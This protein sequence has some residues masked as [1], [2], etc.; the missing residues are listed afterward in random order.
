MNDTQIESLLRQ[1]PRPPAPTGLK[2]QLLADIRL[3]Q[4]QVS[5]V[6]AVDAAPFW[7]RWHPA[8][9]E[10]LPELRATSTAS[11]M[12]YASTDLLR[13]RNEVRQLRAQQPELDRLRDENRRLAAEISSGIASPQKLSGME[14]FVAKESWSNAGF[15][16]PEAA[17]QTCFRAIREG[18]LARLAECMPPKERQYLLRR[19]EQGYEQERGRTL[20]EF[21]GLTQGSGFRIVNRAEEQPPRGALSIVDGIIVE[22][23]SAPA[24][25]TFH[26]QAVAGGAVVPIHLR[27]YAD[28]WKVL[29]F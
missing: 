26:L 19:M 28:G 14:G 15:D 20:S 27:R 11:Q 16:T 4:S 18:D 23:T 24:R 1:A 5:P 21:Q 6:G 8:F 9:V 3:P 10:E 17:L 29:G 13:L 12:S 2:Q 7:R 25:V 22:G